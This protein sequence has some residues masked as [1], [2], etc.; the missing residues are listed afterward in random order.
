MANG[1]VL[2]S[3]GGKYDNIKTVANDSAL[4]QR[5]MR[6]SPDSPKLKAMHT[7]HFWGSSFCWVNGLLSL[8]KFIEEN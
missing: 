2:P 4:S 3:S 6:W 5:E 1:Y 7:V 8:F